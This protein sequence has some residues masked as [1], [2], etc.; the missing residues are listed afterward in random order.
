[1]GELMEMRR[2]LFVDGPYHGDWLTVDVGCGVLALRK[3]RLELTASDAARGDLVC[4]YERRSLMDGM[5]GGFY[6][7]CVGLSDEKDGE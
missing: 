4:T 5:G 7:V 1:M 3:S 2:C 6:Y